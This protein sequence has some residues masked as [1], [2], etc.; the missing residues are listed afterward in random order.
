M[1]DVAT[2]ASEIAS[3]HLKT[4]SMVKQFRSGQGITSKVFY[5]GMLGFLNNLNSY[6]S[7]GRLKC[8]EFVHCR[9]L[10]V[11]LETPIFSAEMVLLKVMNG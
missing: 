9:L 11:H 5:N 6:E 10:G 1:K 2:S 4:E 3:L 8:R 7:N